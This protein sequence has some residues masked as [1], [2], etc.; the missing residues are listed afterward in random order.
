MPASLLLDSDILID[1][2][3]KEQKALD[4]LQREI[5]A[6]S[7]LFISVISRTEIFSGVRKGEE[8]TI[9]SLFDLLTPV[10]VDM[11]IADRAGEYLKKFAKSHSVTIGD[12]II[13][14]TAKEMG[15][16][17]VTRNLKH[18]PMKDLKIIKPY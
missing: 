8:E 9:Q 3:R 2:L 5:D 15:G 10:D 16:T 17:L 4:Y 6:G 11:A 13:A 14:A 1:H 12:A 7:L 18:Y